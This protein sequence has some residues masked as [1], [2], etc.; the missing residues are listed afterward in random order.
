MKKLDAA[1][2]DA[3]GRTLAVK[4]QEYSMP[5]VRDIVAYRAE[6][7]FNPGAVGDGVVDFIAYISKSYG[8]IRYA[9]ELLLGAGII[10][11]RQGFDR[12]GASEVRM[13]HAAIPKGVNGAFYHEELSL[14]KHVLLKSIMGTLDATSEPFVTFE[15][16]KTNYV[17]LCGYYNLEPEEDQTLLEYLETEGYILLR[18]KRQEV[19][20]GMKYPFNRLEEA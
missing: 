4:L 14:Q 18:K 6:E 11:E 10:A 8:G 16:V 7:A 19:K 2:L 12:V 17:E 1:T 3:L 15:D 5:Q 20:I 9:L 13:A